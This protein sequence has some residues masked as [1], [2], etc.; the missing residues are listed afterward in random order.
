MNV[1]E[2]TGGKRMRSKKVLSVFMALAVAGATLAGCSSSKSTTS[3]KP[4][5][6]G[7]VTDTG[8]VNDQSFNESAWNGLQSLQKNVPGVKAKYLQSEQSSD[9]TP[10]LNQF[11]NNKYNLVWG[12]GYLMDGAVKSAAQAYPN[13]TFAIID[14][15][16]NPNAPKNTVGVVF[17][18][19]ESSFLV[20]YIAALKTK[21]NKVGFIGGIKGVVIDQFQYGFQAGVAYGAK[22]LKK[23]ISVNV[24]YA[25]SFS[26]SALGKGI[27]QNMYA[28][29]CD[30]VFAAAGNVG[31]GVISEAKDENKL[32]IGVDQDQ[33]HLAPNNVLVSAMKKVDTAV[34]LISKKIK[35]GEK[36]GGKTFTFGL[37]EA[38]VGIPNTD[39]VKTMCGKDVIDKANKLSDSIKSGSIVPPYNEAT[40]KTYAASLK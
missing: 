6:V 28:N 34:E 36:I 32:V 40:Y 30:I 18:A 12:I 19:Q 26:D 24:Q 15:D 21:T 20:G 9:Y 11:A 37:K 2:V 8:G 35:N 31:Q 7:M 25:N 5:N 39:Q 4:F 33:S 14:D 38:C 1:K 27:A 23:D 3:A 10:N 29:G 22:E 17:K 13:S 16:L